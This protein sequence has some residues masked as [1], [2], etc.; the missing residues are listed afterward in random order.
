VIT[1]VYME[2]GGAADDHPARN[3]VP[4]WGGNLATN[5]LIVEVAK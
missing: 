3:G 2:R 1:G 4:L 5:T